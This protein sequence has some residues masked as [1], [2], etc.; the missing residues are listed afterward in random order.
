M[1]TTK[2]LKTLDFIELEKDQ[3]EEGITINKVL[4]TA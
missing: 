2:Q 3:Y 1:T 4:R